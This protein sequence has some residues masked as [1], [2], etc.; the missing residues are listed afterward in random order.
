MKL[1][2]NVFLSTIFICL[3][4]LVYIFVAARPL[5]KELQ[6]TPQWTVNISPVDIVNTQ[7]VS[8]QLP[9][10]LGQMMGYF[11]SDGKIVSAETFPYKASISSNFYAKYGSDDPEIPFFSSNGVQTGTI[12][13]SGFP[14]FEDDRIFMFFPGGCSFMQCNTDGTEKWRYE[15]VMPVTAFSSSP[16]GCV[17]GFADGTLCTFSPAGKVL[18]QFSPGGSDYDVILGAAYSPD[19]KYVACV[20]G[21]NRQRIVVAKCDKD[22]CIITFFKYFNKDLTRQTLVQFNKKSN[23]VYYNY[24]DGL[25]I[26]N[27]ITNECKEIPVNGKVIAI[28]E[29]EKANTAYA[30]TKNGTTY[31]VYAI[32]G[33]NSL[34]GSFSFTASSAFILAHDDS[35]FVGRDSRIS[36]FKLTRN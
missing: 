31:S 13:S 10:R 22:H 36:R 14:F 2:K 21:Q 32:E 28:Q 16:A 30:L 12:K 35:L 9:F 11:T 7:A 3:F 23:I 25:G 24:A 17:A 33:Q 1:K 4:F 20:S 26:V 18:Q 29:S 5:G 6:M 19:G 27:C 8:G 34:L 15:G